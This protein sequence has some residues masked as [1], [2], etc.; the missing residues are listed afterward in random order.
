VCAG[1]V[2]VEVVV[3][4]RGDVA[5]GPVAGLFRSA[6]ALEVMARDPSLGV[7]LELAVSLLRKGVDAG[8]ALADAVAYTRSATMADAVDRRR[9]WGL[10]PYCVPRPEVDTLGRPKPLRVG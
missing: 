7:R 1:Q 8:L 9:R 6:L 4:R 2:K 3:E 10:G 5:G